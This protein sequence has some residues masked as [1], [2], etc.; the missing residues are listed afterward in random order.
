MQATVGSG[1]QVVEWAVKLRQ[2]DEAGRLD[3]LF[4]EGKLSADD[5]ARLGAE[6]ARVE[7]RL[8]VADPQAGW[9]TPDAFAATVALNLDQIREPRPQAASRADSLQAWIAA[10]LARLGHAFAARVAAGKIR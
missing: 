8:A 4:D 2:F 3:R 9:G 6:I 5:C 10:E 1:G 7:E